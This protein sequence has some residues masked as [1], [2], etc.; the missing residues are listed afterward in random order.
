LPV[1]GGAAERALAG[2]DQARLAVLSYIETFHNRRRRH[3]A[4]GYPSPIEFE[5]IKQEARAITGAA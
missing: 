3:T 5:K 4:L 2:R 1:H